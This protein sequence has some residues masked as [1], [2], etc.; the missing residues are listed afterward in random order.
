MVCPFTAFAFAFACLVCTGASSSSQAKKRIQLSVEEKLWLCERK[1]SH[2][3]TNAQ[4]AVAFDKHFDVTYA[5]TKSTLS[6]ILKDGDKWRAAVAVQ[7]ACGKPTKRLRSAKEP[8]LEEALVTWLTITVSN[9]GP[10]SDLLLTNKA[11]K[12]AEELGCEGIAFSTG[13]LRNFKGRYN[14]KSYK[15]VGEASSA[16]D[17]CNELRTAPSKVR[18]I[19]TTNHSI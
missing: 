14:V 1:K 4:L 17:E 16:D 19:D 13:W 15:L 6:G 11:K 10:V 9:C 2:K 8:Q 7:A 3:E 12:I 5:L 18:Y